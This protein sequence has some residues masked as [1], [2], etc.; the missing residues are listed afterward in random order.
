MIFGFHISVHLG[1]IY[2]QEHKLQSTAVGTRDF[3]GVLEF[4]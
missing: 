2:H 3:Y 4:G 1:N